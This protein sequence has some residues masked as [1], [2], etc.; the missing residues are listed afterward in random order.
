MTTVVTTPV[1]L[2][3]CRLCLNK[4]PSRVNIF[5]GDFPRMLDVLTSIKVHEEDGL[6]KYSCTKCAKDVQ[7]ALMVKKR[8]IKAHQLLSEALKK[9]RAV[10]QRVVITP[11][12]NK[13]E[14]SVPKKTPTK[15]KVVSKKTIPIIK[16]NRTQRKP[17]LVDNSNEAT[18]NE[19]ENEGSVKCDIKIEEVETNTIKEEKESLAQDVHEILDEVQKRI[20]SNGFTCETCNLTFSDKP[21]FYLHRLKHKKGKCHICGRFVRKD[22]LKKHIML[23]TAGPSVC[24]TC[25]AT[26]KNFESLRG[27]IFHYHKHT[28]HQYICEECGKG[29]RMKNKFILHKK[30][31][32]MGLRN[33]KCSTCGKAFFTNTDLVS[34]VRMTHEKL[35]PHVCEYCGTGFSTKHVLKTHKRQHTNEKPF[36]CNHCFEGFRQRVSLRSHLK[37]KHGI[38]E[39]KEFICKTCEKG[40]ATDYA[41]NIHQ[42]LHA[43]KKCKI[44]S[45]NFG[46]DEYLTKHLREVH[47]VKEEMEQ[48][49]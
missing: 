33:F 43:T 38:E 42:R 28:A 23:H 16:Q 46:G 26:C 4:T 17:K 40:F 47:Q 31:V 25:G 14:S 10:F 5:G 2:Y 15:Q 29:F 21:A 12:V 7:M 18:T 24:S 9:K 8:I 48:D 44:C 45:E 36:V 39:V 1:A 11:V 34:H 32:H 27:H 19:D 30:K 22:N 37:S 20:K 6:P 35:R 13:V 3:Q 41:L 49:S